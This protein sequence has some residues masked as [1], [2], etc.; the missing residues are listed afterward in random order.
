M[1]ALYAATVGV[2]TACGIYLVLRGEPFPS[3]W[4]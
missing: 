2:L 1:E 3:S 4:G